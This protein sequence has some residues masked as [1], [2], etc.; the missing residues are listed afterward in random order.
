MRRHGWWPRTITMI[1]GIML[2]RCIATIA[3][4]LAVPAVLCNG[5]A[6]AKAKAKVSVGTDVP[7][8]GQYKAPASNDDDKPRGLSGMACLA[9]KP[10]AGKGGDP[11]RECVALIDE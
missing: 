2:F 4:A 9:E 3:L 8:L 11:A 6:G 7:P 1:G 5:A 10:A